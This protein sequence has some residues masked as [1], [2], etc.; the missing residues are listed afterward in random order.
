MTLSTIE[1]LRSDGFEDLVVFFGAGIGVPAGL[2]TAWE[3]VN[4]IAAELVAE[5][6][7][8]EK[9]VGLVQPG[10]PLRFETAMEELTETADPSLDVLSFLD[11]TEPGHLHRAVAWAGAHGARLVTVNF[12]DLVEQALDEREMRPSTVDAQRESPAPAAPGVEV[13][14]LHGTRWIHGGS[15]RHF[16]DR[17]LHA[18]IREIVRSGGGISL[19]PQAHELL[20]STLEGKQLLV[21]GYSGSDDLDVMPSLARCR[22]AAVTWV[23]HA[24]AAVAVPDDLV[25][26]GIERLLESWRDAGV[27]VRLVAEETSRFLVGQGWDLPDPISEEERALRVAGWRNGLT[28]WARKARVEDPS[29]LGWAALLFGSLARE[30]EKMLAVEQSI[31]SP[32]PDGP[33]SEQ[34]RLYE[35]AQCA[36]FSPRFGAD[37]VVARAEEARDRSLANHDPGMAANSEIMIAREV[38][39]HRRYEEAE[40]ALARARSILDSASQANSY[41]RAYLELWTGRLRLLQADGEGALV[42]AR[43]AAEIYEQ[44]GDAAALSES[45]QIIGQVAWFESDFASAIEPLDRAIDLARKG[46]YAD[47]LDPALQRRACV[48]YYDGDVETCYEHAKESSE[49]CFK[50]RLTEEVA[51]SL[52]PWGTAAN[53]LGMFAEAR[54]AFEQARFYCTEFEDNAWRPD[55]VLGLADSLLHLGEVEAALAVL[56]EEASVVERDPWDIAHAEAIRWRAGTRTGGQADAA[57]ARA[58][59]A[60]PDPLPRPAL[61]LLRLRVPG[62]ASERLLRHAEGIMADTRH[63]R[64]RERLRSWLD[65]E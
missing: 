58:L 7:W 4:A 64:R 5:P 15:E 33:W 3:L 8:V 24:P 18:T 48:A 54:D 61:C 63:R 36:Y 10:G 2:P 41:S 65:A 39:G 6:E 50:A 14:K 37:E 55:I 27:E 30:E 53:E 35:L 59:D 20:A 25:S 16:S 11:S 42:A 1:S 38:S 60:D 28:G 57:V 56:D 47:Q 23:Q 45:L 19:P 46:P 22:P 29:G 43:R 52:S 31:P 13:L 26:E 49:V 21:L 9:I 32:K 62:P 12:D 40:S 44:K 34:R 51:E 17:P